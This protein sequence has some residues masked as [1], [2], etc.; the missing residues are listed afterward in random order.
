MTSLVDAFAGVPDARKS[1]GGSYRLPHVL[2][3]VL[4]ARLCGCDSLRSMAAW[5]AASKE[6]LN[7]RLGFGWHRTPRKSGLAAILK[8]VDTDAL[9]SVL[10]LTAKG[11]GDLVHADGK[12]LRGEGVCALSVFASTDRECLARIAFAPGKE[13]DCLAAWLASGKARRRMVTG[14][15]A[16]CQKKRSPRPPRASAT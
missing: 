4:L 3:A 2:S 11:G 10:T 14:D 9:A 8:T 13:A 7:E 1:Q 5:M 15:A 16:H 12:T 6:D